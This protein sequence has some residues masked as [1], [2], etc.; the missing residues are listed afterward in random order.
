MVLSALSCLPAIFPVDTGICGVFDCDMLDTL[1]LSPLRP[2]LS[3][4]TL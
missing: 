1:S 3:F 4:A 2:L